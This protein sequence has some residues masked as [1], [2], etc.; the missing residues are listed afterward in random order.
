MLRFVLLFVL[1]CSA[2]TGRA[3][4]V[5]VLGD[6]SYAP[7]IS[8]QS[9][10]PSGVLVDVLRFASSDMHVPIVIRLYPWKRA[11]ELSLRQGAGIV[12]ISYTAERAK[13][14]DFSDPIYDD[15]IN[16]VVMHGHEF[17]FSGP[18]DL[19]GKRVGGQVGASYGEAT[20]Q[21]LA[22]ALVEIDRDVNQVARLR[23]L[24]VGHLDCA[25]IGNGVVGLQHIIESDPDLQMHAH[26]FVILPIPLARDALFL[27]FPKEA[28]QAPFLAEFNRSLARWVAQNRK[29]GP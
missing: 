21:A 7:V 4:E 13:R 6:E 28:R 16:I 20:D 26:E 29:T 15:N 1:C 27:A 3:A 2:L 22:G 23:K 8:Q 18:S 19:R 14:F 12:G 9:S 10:G 24:M 5:L 17:P 11:Y 25:I